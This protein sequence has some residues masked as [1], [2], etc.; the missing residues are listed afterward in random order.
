MDKWY[1]ENVSIIG[2]IKNGNLIN[3]FG[4]NY[5]NLHSERFGHVILSGSGSHAMADSLARLGPSP[6]YPPNRNVLERAVVTALT[7]STDILGQ[8]LI[9]PQG[10]RNYFGGGIE[11]SGYP[12]NS[13]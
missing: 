1:K 5:Q 10:L 2:F 9:S 12:L 3:S 13:G 7:I 6:E 8:E 4:F 11:L